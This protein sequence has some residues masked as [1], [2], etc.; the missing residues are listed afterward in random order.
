[1]KKLFY[2]PIVHNSADLGS[3]GSQLSSE[4]ARKYGDSLWK[5]HLEQVDKSW[6]NVEIEIFKQ[7]KRTPFTKVKIYQDGLPVV[8]EIGIKIVNDTAKNGSKNYLIIERLLARGAKLELA[9]DKALLLKEY[10]LLADINNAETPEKQMESFLTY[11][12]MSQE[13][14]NSRDVFIANQINMTLQVGEWG[15]AFFGASHSIVDKINKDIKVVV[16]Q[17]F[18]DSISLSLIKKQ[19]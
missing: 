19:Q 13:L 9:E 2:I 15:I 16:I 3:L 18:K 8:D 1:M 5:D 6:N 14:L 7:L 11:Q 12:N 10:Y 17:M 4:G